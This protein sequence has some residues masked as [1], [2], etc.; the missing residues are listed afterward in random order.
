[1]A[2]WA[3]KRL[4][5]LGSSATFKSL[6]SFFSITTTATIVQM[7][8]MNTAVSCRKVIGCP[9]FFDAFALADDTSEGAE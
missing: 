8:K 9:L 1:M 6:G 2:L 3:M 5:Y 7:M 4:G